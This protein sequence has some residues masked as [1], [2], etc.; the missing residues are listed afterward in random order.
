MAKATK[1][2]RGKLSDS[3]VHQLRRA[4]QALS[5]IWQLQLPELTPPQ[6]A[7]L[8]TLAEHEELSQTELGAL[9][10]LDASTLTPLLDRLE[11]RDLISKTI[12]PTN[13]RRRRISITATGQQQ[14]TRAYAQVTKT[15]EWISEVLGEVK[16]RELVDT[17]RT[18]G[19]ASRGYTLPT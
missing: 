3:A 1:P 9:I 7:V 4:S 16:A 6:F 12:D 19:D 14:L 10:S 8:F 2:Q 17:L 13:R 18:L 5:A 11:G 15:H